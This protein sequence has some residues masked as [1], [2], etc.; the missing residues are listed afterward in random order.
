[1]TLFDGLKFERWGEV[2]ET[3]FARQSLVD[4]ETS[5]FHQ[6]WN[7]GFQYCHTRMYESIWH[8]I[9]GYDSSILLV[10]GLQGRFSQ[11]IDIIGLLHE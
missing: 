4:N 7:Q 1:V 5:T 3:P 11:C 9:S 10:N 6:G 2:V 8:Q